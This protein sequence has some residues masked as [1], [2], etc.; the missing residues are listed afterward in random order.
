MT[1]ATRFVNFFLKKGEKQ[2]RS[3]EK[4]YIFTYMLVE[5]RLVSSFNTTKLSYSMNGFALK[6][7]KKRDG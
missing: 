1:S 4:A 6:Y 2:Q 7:Y 3:D 5:C